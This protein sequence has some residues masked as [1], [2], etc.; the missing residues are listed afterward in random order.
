MW[1]PA[2]RRYTSYV[3]SGLLTAG[4]LVSGRLPAQQIP[5]PWSSISDLTPEQRDALGRL[6]DDFDARLEQRRAEIVHAVQTRGRNRTSL[7]LAREIELRTRNLDVPFR[8]ELRNAV[9]EVLTPA[10]VAQANELWEVT[11]QTAAAVDFDRVKAKQQTA[12]WCWAAIIQMIFA[13]SGIEVTQS[14]IV[15][16]IKGSVVFDRASIQEIEWGVTES[17]FNPARVSSDWSTQCKYFE[18]VPPDHI[19]VAMLH[20]SRVIVVSVEQQHLVAL[21]KA[22][23]VESTQVRVQNVTIYD[24]ATGEDILWTPSQLHEYATGFWECWVGLTRN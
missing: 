1:Q 2:F 23:Y 22:D 14:E 24:P 5:E 3:V 11:V 17:L 19:I 12:L 4:I 7:P 15:S 13:Y 21:H 16:E 9:E 6:I 10:Q 18:G 8:R 20:Q